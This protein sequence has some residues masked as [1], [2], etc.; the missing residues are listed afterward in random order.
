MKIKLLFVGMVFAL[1]GCSK[2]SAEQM[3]NKGADAQKAEQYDTAIASY[4]ELIKAY[5]DSARTPE[6]YYAVGT[7]YQNNK[8]SYHQA[9]DI[10]RQLENTYPSH[11]T[12]SSASFL[13]GFIYNND[14]KNIDSARI[15]YE[16]FMKR[17]PTN[18]LVTS[19]QFEIT[20]LGKDPAEILK[21]QTQV[22]A[23]KEKLGKKG[24]KK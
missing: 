13:I 6:A 20:N 18:Q 9:I 8:K 23:E 15:A 10:F 2:P 17:Y 22:I 21:L 4:L 14:L 1:V 19:A 11:A 12:A 7:I 3:Y 24:K 5:P 16:D